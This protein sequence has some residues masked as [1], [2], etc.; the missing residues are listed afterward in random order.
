MYG[1][2][3]AAYVDAAAGTAV[4]A[5]IAVA[6]VHVHPVLSAKFWS[7][8]FGIALNTIHIDFLRGAYMVHDE[9]SL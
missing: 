5:D 4:V 2:V 3:V 1:S 9:E 6:E 8:C 7:L